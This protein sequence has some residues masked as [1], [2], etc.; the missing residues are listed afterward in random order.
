MMK[1]DTTWIRDIGCTEVSWHCITAAQTPQKRYS[2]LPNTS[3]ETSPEV[4]SPYYWDC[5]S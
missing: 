5:Q 4:L 3:W 2:L 1:R